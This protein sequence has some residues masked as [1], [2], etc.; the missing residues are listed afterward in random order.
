MWNRNEQ[1]ICAISTPHGVGGLA[2]IRISGPHAL[3]FSQKITKALK[4]KPALESHRAYFSEITDLEGVKVDEAVV[5]Y[6]AEGKSFTG[7]EVVEISC[8]GSRYIAQQVLDLLVLC[9]CR[10]AEKGE[11]T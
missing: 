6:F 10:M 8:H 7:E 11:F 3:R 2:V 5:T 9:G 4:N 1:T